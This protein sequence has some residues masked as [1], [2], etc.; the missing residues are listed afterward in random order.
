MVLRVSDRPRL[1]PDLQVMTLIMSICMEA[2][3]VFIRTA[4][5]VPVLE[6]RAALSR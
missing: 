2:A 1:F 3:A 6:M 4:P 5:N